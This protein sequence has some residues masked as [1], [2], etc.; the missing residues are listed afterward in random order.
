[1]SIALNRF[2]S[3]DTDYIGKM[4]SDSVAL[5]TA[6]NAIQASL[7]GSTD[8]STTIFLAGLF[9]NT[10]TLIG[11][12]SYLPGGSGTNLTVA[13][14]AAYRN[15]SQ[16]VVQSIAPGTLAF[17]GQSAGTYYVVPD[18][19][20][21]ATRQTSSVDALYSVV[22]TGSA[23]GAIT[24]VAPALFD[25][26]EENAARS[27][28]RLGDF[29]T[30]DARLEAAEGVTATAADDAVNA[31]A[32]AYSVLG[33]AGDVNG[34][35]SAVDGH[36]AVFDGVTGK[37]IKDGGARIRKVALSLD[38]SGSVLT[39][40]VKGQ[41]QVD[42][43]GTI[44]GW[45][46]IGDQSGSISVEVDKK[47][48]SAPAAAPA[49]PNTT[50]DKISA[51]APIALSSAQ[52]ASSAASGVSSWTTAVALWDVIQFNVASVTTLTRVTLYLRIQES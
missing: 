36:L 20:G 19:N 14:G 11:T 13:P 43:A 37:L 27:S 31:L 39:T 7:G 2:A 49:V 4:N 24:K 50:T 47:A 35:G 26:T 5:E 6:I 21:F 9:K 16:T 32:L 22:W 29:S 38:G 23:F 10:T 18:I 41:I 42:F 44:I 33:S 8:V 45:S 12:G 15:S 1:M 48:S 3:G 17:A 30:L 40:G 46:I 51:S 34:P 52:S 28:V 25:A